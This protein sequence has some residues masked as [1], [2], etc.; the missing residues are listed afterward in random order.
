MDVDEIFDILGLFIGDHK[1]APAWTRVT[2]PVSTRASNV[3]S[4]TGRTTP[5]RSRTATPASSGRAPR[6]HAMTNQAPA[7]A[8]RPLDGPWRTRISHD[9]MAVAYFLRFDAKIRVVTIAAILRLNYDTIKCALQ[10][11]ARRRDDPHWVNPED[12]NSE[13]TTAELAVSMEVHHLYG[14]LNDEHFVTCVGRNTTLEVLRYPGDQRSEWNVRRTIKLIRSARVSIDLSMYSFTLCVYAR[15][16][17]AVHRPPSSRN[18]RP[19]AG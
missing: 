17:L 5:T 6:V 8:Y 16:I 7:R 18:Q 4:A 15:D 9:L 11:E 3:A 12:D 13:P 14:L 1:S 10:R 2:A 19:S